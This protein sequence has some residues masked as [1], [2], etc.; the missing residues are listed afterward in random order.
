MCGLLF[1]AQS[2]STAQ[3][4]KLAL[5][6]SPLVLRGPDSQSITITERFIFAHYL[7]SITGTHVQQPIS[8]DRIHAAF[9]GEVY[10]LLDLNEPTEI[11]A[12][13]N[14]EWTLSHIKDRVCRIDGEF[15][16]ILA[17]ECANEVVAITDLFATKPLWFGVSSANSQWGLASYPT[18][19]S[20]LGADR[21]KQIPAN[22][23]CFFDLE[24]GLLKNVARHTHLSLN[25]HKDSFSEWHNAFEAAVLKRAS[26]QHPVTVP[27]SSGYD[28]G[29]IAAAMISLGITGTYCSFRAEENLQILEQR[30]S[31]LKPHAKY[32]E[33]TQLDV[34]RH[35]ERIRRFTPDFYYSTYLFNA[36]Y[37]MSADPGAIGLSAICED[38]S[39]RESRVLLSGQ[40]ADEILSDYGLNGT[41]LS[42][43]SFLGGIFPKDLTEI[44]PWPN[45]LGGVNRCYLLKD[46]YVTGSHGIEG[47]Y[48]FLDKSL[49]QEFLWLTNSLK[50]S[51]YKAPLASY[52]K[53]QDFPVEYDTKRGFNATHGVL[54]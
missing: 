44:Y 26:S 39:T 46:E 8:R 30:H 25:Q 6:H 42:Q 36:E 9:N 16:A 19:L 1:W 23:I 32:I 29:G 18:I 43:D 12:F 13:L 17:N 54:T 27:L 22:C 10:N 51:A 52:L 37:L 35:S 38:A 34:H 5:E 11:E 45:F 33:L 2:P 40:G 28:S 48:P 15:A 7:L 3:I 47:R 4:A 20:A 53:L 24:T 41:K 21:I 14:T 49:V 31:L 50:N